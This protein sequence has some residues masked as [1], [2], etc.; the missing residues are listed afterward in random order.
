[1]ADKLHKKSIL[2]TTAGVS[3][4]LLFSK[5]MGVVREIVQVSYLGVG[6]LSD[7]FNT[8]MKIPTLL[9]RLFAEGA[10]R[11]AFVP[12]IIRVT[13]EDS[14]EQASRLMTLTYMVFGSLVLLL[15]VIISL[16]PQP[17]IFLIAKGFADKP[18]E[19]A[20]AMDIIR[21]VVFYVF[22]LFTSALLATALQAKM[23]FTVPAFGPALLNVFYIG[24]LLIS[25]YFG[26]SVDMFCLFLLLGG[27]VQALLFAYVYFRL[28]FAILWPDMITYGYF[29]QVMYKF[30]PC[31][32]SVSPIAINLIVDNRFASTLPAGSL[33]LLSISSKFM[34]ITLGAF[35][36]AFSTIL[37]SHFSR[38]STYAP[39]RLSYYLLESTKLIFW[40]TIPVVF[41]M[42][43]F[44]YDIFYTIFYRLAGNFTLA[45]VGQAST[46][47][48]A[49]LPGL[50]FSSINK[51][52][53]S[54]LYA[55]HKTRYAMYTTIGGVGTNF[56]LNRLLMPYYGALGIAMA[57]AIA[58]AVQSI[59]LLIVLRT[60]LGFTLYLKRFAEFVMAYILQLLLFIG[61]FLVLYNLGVFGI[62]YGMPG[63][64]DVLLHNVGLWFWI[65][66]ICLIAVGVLYY[67]R[68]TFGVHMYFLD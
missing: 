31:L 20:L 7:A 4:A 65:G 37:L 5:M 16:F 54:L 26:L 45:Q 6:S 23:H 49:F 46:L 14:Q 38:V 39:K 11:A 36:E 60:R 47:L 30:I 13:S 44:A 40:V 55:L 58:A 62:T 34:M 48:I 66:P 67:I 12:T 1:M 8:A 52:L 56:L 10:L 29:K 35:A 27:L 42:S 41:L 57:T 33:T 9:R 43:F 19:M 61:V 25:M 68:K 53:L 28:N 51:I 64:K 3:A 22:F 63:F 59:L 32:M 24:G 50:F 18:K 15:C 17:F 2:K 21:I